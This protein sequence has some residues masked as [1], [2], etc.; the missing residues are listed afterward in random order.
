MCSCGRSVWHEQPVL[1]YSAGG[2]RL[3]GK[4]RAE[5]RQ[6]RLVAKSWLLSYCMQL[7]FIPLLEAGLIEDYN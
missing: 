3:A 6:A 1:T 2:L 5:I 7:G 4:N